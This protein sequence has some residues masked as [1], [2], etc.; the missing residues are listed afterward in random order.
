MQYICICGPAGPRGCGSAMAGK[1]SGE[2]MN[3]ERGKMESRV[4]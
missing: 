1:E 4:G 2:R 3:E